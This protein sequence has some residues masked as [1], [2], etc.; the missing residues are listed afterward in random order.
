MPR[1]PFL[2]IIFQT[3]FIIELLSKC[4]DLMILH[5]YF[6]NECFKAKRY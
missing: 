2:N 6:F 3:D 1:P 4:R 5:R